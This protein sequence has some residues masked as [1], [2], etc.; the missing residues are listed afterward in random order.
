MTAK[1]KNIMLGTA[2]HVGQGKSA[3]VKLLTQQHGGRGGTAR[4]CLHMLVMALSLVPVFICISAESR[5]GM[6]ASVNA[7]ATDAGVAVLQNGGNAVDAAV[8]VV[9]TL[10]VVDG[11]NSGIGGGCLMLIRTAKGRIVAIDGREKAG[12]AATRDMFVKDGKAQTQLSQ[13]GALAIGVPGSVAAYEYAVRK[14]GR[15]SLKELIT[16]AAELAERGFVVSAG[17]AKTLRSV[18]N[19]LGSF[20]A[21]RAVFFNGDRPIGEGELLRQPELAA[22]Y[23]AIANKGSKWF[24]RGSFAEAVGEWMASNGGIVTRRDFR[25]YEIVLREPIITYYRDY[26]IVGFAPPSSGGVNVAEILNIVQYYDVPRLTPAQ[27][28]HVLAEAMKL[29]FA[30][31]AYWLGDADFA[32]VP[33]G[34]LDGGYAAD[35]ARTIRPARA[36]VVKSHGRPPGWETD[37]FKRHTTHFCVADA[38]GNWVACTTTVNTSFGSKV[39]IPGTGVVM[40]NQMD[41]FSIQPGTTNYF[42]LVGAEANAV[43]PGKRPLSSMSPTIVLKDD[44]PVAALG[45]AGGPTIISQVVQELIWMLDLKMGP[46]EALAQPRIHHQWLPDELVVEKRLPA[47]VKEALRGY[48]HKVREVES[49]GASQIIIRQPDGTFRGEA[50]PRVK[51]KADGL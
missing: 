29:A 21:S 15:K 51:G 4:K 5:R 2:G 14:Y 38:E 46:A 18:S 43:G 35:L 45:A 33:R 8:A 28:L 42:G 50:D 40:N 22:S 49:L 24:Y 6:V 37:L 10:G 32:P 11:H 16:P 3:L 26:E 20:S 12:A 9:F 13:T 19:E 39:V 27:R 31:R 7:Q 48:G 41:D 17:Y 1:R 44:Q 23:R 30:D 34:L 47:D 25:D 36:N